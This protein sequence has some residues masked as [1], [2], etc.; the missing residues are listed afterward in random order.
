M[1]KLERG[2]QPQH[3]LHFSQHSLQTTR[4]EGNLVV[5]VERDS[6]KIR[7]VVSFNPDSLTDF[8]TVV[9]ATYGTFWQTPHIVQHVLRVMLSGF[10]IA[11][12]VFFLCLHRVDP[13]KLEYTS[14]NMCTTMLGTFLGFIFA[15][16]VNSTFMRWRQVINYIFTYFEQVKDLQFELTVIHGV[17]ADAWERIRRWSILSIW[18]ATREA[19]ELWENISWKGEFDQ[20][21]KSTLMRKEE[22]KILEDISK[23]A[24]TKRALLVWKWITHELSELAN[25]GKLPP[26]MS[27]AFVHIL[28][29]CKNAREAIGM[30]ESVIF[31]QMPYIYVHLLAMLIQLFCVL[32]SIT[33][34]LGMGIH[35]ARLVHHLHR[36]GSEESWVNNIEKIGAFVLLLG[37]GPLIYQTSLS[38]SLELSLPFGRTSADLP[39]STLIAMQE[40]QLQQV[41]DFPNEPNATSDSKKE[42]LHSTSHTDSITLK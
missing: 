16:F 19:P 24:P 22:R 11:V 37:V 17:P 33:C 38:V 9:F 28:E 12:L 13:T 10:T 7:K 5:Q 23:N 31:L 4:H 8:W 3:L 1:D 29:D 26:K 42:L 39:M 14:L 36:P 18:I 30:L 35:A 15:T 2:K 6:G 41:S 34:G 20:W 21:E 27:P 40:M 32:N 25:N